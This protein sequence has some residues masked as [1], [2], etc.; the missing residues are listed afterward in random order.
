MKVII[1]GA[2]GLVATELAIRLL[3][4]DDAVE[5]TLVSRRPHELSDRYAQFSS[6][7]KSL[8]LDELMHSESESYDICV[9]TAF[10]RS[11][12]GDKIVESLNYSIRLFKWAKN[13][14]IP[15]FVNISSQSVYGNSYEPYIDEYAPCAPD[16]MYALAKYSSELLARNIFDKSDTDLV[17]IR[18]SSVCENARFIKVF[19]SNVINHRPI[20]L[21]APNQVVSFI[22]VRDVAEAITKVIYASTFISGDF[23]LGS[24]QVYSIKDVS[25]LVRE[26]GQ[27]KFNL[28]EI[29]I[30]IE[31][32]GTTS[33]VGMS[34][35]KF[36]TTYDW[37]P[38]LNI[39]DM[40]TSLFNM[41]ID[42]NGGGYPASFKLVYNL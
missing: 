32:N 13:Q 31:D 34:I 16:Y 6:R 21:V 19:V 29:E 41:L 17:N 39:G 11:S 27:Q 1:T 5:L 40:I 9:H 18:L 28:P 25:L 33:Q 14:G 4:I 10:A 23:N 26:I 24:G 42:V 20:K 36:C 35:K 38:R 3:S 2:S 30:E 15:R 22:D 37:K 7:I 8:T 12:S